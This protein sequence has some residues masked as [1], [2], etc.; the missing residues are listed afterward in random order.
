MSTRPIGAI[1]FDLWDC[2]FADESDEPK[3]AA[4]G[5][6][7]KKVERRALVHEALSRHGAIDRAAV[8]L[9]YDVTDAA[10]NHVWHAI[11]VTWTVRE[12]LGVLLKGLNRALPEDELARLVHLHEDMELEFRP[13]PAPGATEALRALHQRYPLAI[14]SDA[15][16]S[17]GRALREL[18]QGAGML[19]YFDFFAFSDEI[20]VSKPHP[21]AF[22]AV[23]Q[24][25]N[26]P[27]QSIVH[28]GD[29]PHN[30]LG[31]PHAV[32]ARG[33]LLTVVK[34][35]PLD[36]HAPDALCDDYATLPQILAGL[37]SCTVAEQSSSRALAERATS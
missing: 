37:G 15:V 8:D 21:N 14:I 18:L 33:V 2:L 13:D 24:H 36:G 28:V 27:V 17:P 20:G 25:F 32:G 29:R 30:D 12:R 6:P 3:R 22:E 7:P 9:A 31:G 16:F 4:A 35:R 11:H 23:A 34:Q 5:R 1:T 19:E 10:F 26:I